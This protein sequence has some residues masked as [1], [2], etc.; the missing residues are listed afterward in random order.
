MIYGLVGNDSLTCP[1]EG[2]GLYNSRVTLWLDNSLVIDLNNCCVIAHICSFMHLISEL[3]IDAINSRGLHCRY[4]IVALLV[5]HNVKEKR[6]SIFA[7][8]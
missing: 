2:N 8:G 7:A 5:L 3:R 4:C 1:I 6:K